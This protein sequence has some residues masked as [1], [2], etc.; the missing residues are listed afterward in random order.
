MAFQSALAGV[1]LAAEIILSASGQRVEAL[2]AVTRLRT[3]RALAAGGLLT[4]L[5]PVAKCMC[6]DPDFLAVFAEKWA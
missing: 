2:P 5:A 4:P 1:L 3:T 6:Q